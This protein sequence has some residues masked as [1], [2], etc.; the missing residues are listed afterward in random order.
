MFNV[1]V[2]ESESLRGGTQEQIQTMMGTENHETKESLFMTSICF[3]EFV[4]L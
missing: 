1:S 4:T 2:I 3:L